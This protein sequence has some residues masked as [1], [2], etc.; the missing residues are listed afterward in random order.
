M[1]CKN[2]GKQIE[3]T[4]K[5]CNQCGY[6]LSDNNNNFTSDDININSV[7]YEGNKCITKAKRTKI[8]II[9][10]IVF[11]LILVVCA[12]LFPTLNSEYTN[13]DSSQTSIANQETK[14]EK[15]TEQTT[16]NVVSDIIVEFDAKRFN[17]ETTIDE[18]KTLYPTGRI[19]ETVIDVDSDGNEI[20]IQMY[21]Y[22][23]YA[24]NFYN[25]KLQSIFIDYTVALYTD[26]EKCPEEPLVCSSI[27][28][29]LPTYGLSGGTITDTEG[30]LYMADNCGIYKF[31]CFHNGANIQNIELCYTDLFIYYN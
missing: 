22:Q 6:P 3:P 2:C 27:D 30:Y 16:K 29:F 10:V 14:S 25:E 28:E 26:P 7:F 24:F 23:N 17:N 31:V 4:F 15:I 5:F 21:L 20:V 18:I 8:I 1:Y 9:C 13:P 19:R 11:L 12:T